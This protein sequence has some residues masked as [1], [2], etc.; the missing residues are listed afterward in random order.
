MSDNVNKEAVKPDVKKDVKPAV[1]KESVVNYHG[2]KVP[3]STVGK[4]KRR[5]LGGKAAG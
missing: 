4:H 5:S 3:E 1:K 2:D